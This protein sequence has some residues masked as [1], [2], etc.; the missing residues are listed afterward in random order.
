M[1]IRKYCGNRPT[2][3]KFRIIDFFVDTILS[4]VGSK[5]KDANNPP[6][7]VLL[8]N[9]GHLGD[10]LM[11]GYMVNAFKKKYPNIKVH[12]VVGRWCKLLVENNPLF[13]EVEYLDHYKTNRQSISVFAKYKIFIRDSISLIKKYRNNDYTHSFDFRYSAHNAN[14]ILPFLKIQQKNGFG[15]RGLGG[16]LDNEYFMLKNETHTI[17]VQAQGLNSLYVDIDS[18][19]IKTF[20]PPYLEKN[21]EI[22]SEKNVFMIFPEAG[23]NNR[24][25]SINFW[26]NVIEVLRSQKSDSQIMI[27]GITDFSK[28]MNDV[29]TTTFGIEVIIPFTKLTIPQIISTLKTSEGAITLDSFP[30]HLATTQT[31]TLCLF[32]EGT[33]IEYFPIN[34]FP[35]YV[36]HNHQFSKNITSFRDKMKIEYIDSFERHDF[37]VTLLTAINYVFNVRKA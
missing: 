29:L 5:K 26:I 34:A 16:F 33:G 27:C 13:D 11:M 20:L 14:F 24:M 1:K 2:K 32:K 4:I 3:L 31:P 9:F 18:A 17:D 10:M 19:N 15:T 30:A 8:F 35:T 23:T 22:K 25:F 28:T 6:Q 37:N 7:Q 21:D 12:L 36:I